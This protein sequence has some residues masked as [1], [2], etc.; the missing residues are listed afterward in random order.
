MISPLLQY[1]ILYIILYI[2]LYVIL[3]INL[4]LKQSVSYIILYYSVPCHPVFSTRLQV[5]H[6][7][8]AAGFSLFSPQHILYIFPY[9]VR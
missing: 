8:A 9:P 6:T 5:K 1:V 7:I 3:C 2:I 4:S